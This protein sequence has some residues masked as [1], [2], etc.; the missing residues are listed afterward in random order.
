MNIH[1]LYQIDFIYNMVS[2][3]EFII[4][5]KIGD[6]AYG[7]VYKVKRTLDNQ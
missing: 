1:Y 5:H 6:G 7:A 3:N 4:S 2:L